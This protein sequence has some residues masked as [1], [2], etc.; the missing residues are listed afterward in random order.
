MQFIS[1]ADSNDVHLL[2][3]CTQVHFLSICT[4]LEYYFFWKLATLTSLHL[5]DKYRTFYTTT[6][7]SKSLSRK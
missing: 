3:Y 6:F 7:L 4:L 1:E 2:E 5:K